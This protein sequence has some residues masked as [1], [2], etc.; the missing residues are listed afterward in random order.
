MKKFRLLVLAFAAM[1]AGTQNG[2]AQTWTGHAPDDLVGLQGQD[3]EVYLW[4]VGTGQFLYVGGNWG[5][6]AIP[7]TRELSLQSQIKVMEHGGV[8]R[9]THIHC[10]VTLLM[11]LR[12]VAILHLQ[13]QVTGPLFMI[14]ALGL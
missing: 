10:R 7:T 9:I 1:L 13:T 11:E 8:V 2:V 12:P 5:T 6:Q 4:N 3:A 14:P